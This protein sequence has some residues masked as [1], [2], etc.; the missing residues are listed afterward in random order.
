MIKKL[1]TTV[2]SIVGWRVEGQ[3]PADKKL[4]IIGAPHT[5]NWDFPLTLL[6]LSALGLRFSWVAKHTLFK[7]PLGP[8]FKAIGGVPVNRKVKSGFL[9]ETVDAFLERDKLILA[10]A[11]E[12]TRSK[13]D[14][15]KAGFYHIAVKA[16]INICLGFIDYPSKTIGLGPIV[17]PSKDIDYDFSVIK[18]FY[19]EKTGRYPA[20]QSEILLREKEIARYRKEVGKKTTP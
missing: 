10:I 15:W 4:L 11:P 1:S 14:H 7:G 8:L 17:S 20:K 9:K 6:A 5:S 13:T 19:Q 2:L 16:N 12:G 3:L 18:E